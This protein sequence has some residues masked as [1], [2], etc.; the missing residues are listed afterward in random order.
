MLPEIDEALTDVQTICNHTGDPLMF[1]CIIVEVARHA[2]DTL[3]QLGSMLPKLYKRRC[4]DCEDV[5]YYYPEAVYC[6][7]C[8]SPRT[9][10]IR[11]EQA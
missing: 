8:N 2:A 3:A 6:R 11:E 9:R 4:N 7:A 1:E 10:P 5:A